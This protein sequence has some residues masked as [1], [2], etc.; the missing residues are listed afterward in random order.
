MMEK[1]RL[2][3]YDRILVSI[4]AAVVRAIAE[5]VGKD[6][7]VRVRT[8]DHVEDTSNWSCSQRVHNTIKCNKL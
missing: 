6:T 4:I 1:Q 3:T 7:Y 8:D 2:T 5:R